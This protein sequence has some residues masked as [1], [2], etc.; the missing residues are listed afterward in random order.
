MNDRQ[1]GRVASKEARKQ[2]ITFYLLQVESKICLTKSNLQCMI[3]M[4][5]ICHIECQMDTVHVRWA[6]VL[7]CTSSCI[8]ARL[9]DGSRMPSSN[10]AALDFAIINALSH[11][12]WRGTFQA[13]GAHAARAH[14][15]RKGR[16]LDTATRCT[17][18]GLHFQP[19][20]LTSQGT[21]STEGAS[22]LHGIAE[23][24]ASAEG[25]GVASI[26][27]DFLE[28]LAVLV[29]RANGR[30]VARRL[31]QHSAGGSAAGAA[32]AAAALL[33]DPGDQ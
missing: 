25:V 19:I 33:R 21:I 7:L 31:R 29:A 6:D 32:V 10:R 18:A 20:V 13:D 4:C 30:A 17:V 14:G 16:H 1:G 9:P 28:R 15:D 22:V 26:F 5:S 12:H 11:G 3:D 23:A 27:E 2:N 24:V 8:S